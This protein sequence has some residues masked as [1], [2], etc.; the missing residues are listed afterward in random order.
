VQ[1][2]T[3][4]SGESTTFT[5]TWPPSVN[6]IWR[7]VRG[8]NILSAEARQWRETA[9]NE[10]LSQ[11][12]L[13]VNGQ[14]EVEIVL[15]SPFNRPFD[16]DNR[17]KAVLDLLVENGIIDGD[18][19]SVLKRITVSVGEDFQGATVTIRSFRG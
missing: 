2:A 16:P 6:Q 9:K 15:R 8:R 4:P 1:R 18:G 19:D 13:P 3:G 17:I 10:L 12:V 5:L 11:H 7:S 14:V